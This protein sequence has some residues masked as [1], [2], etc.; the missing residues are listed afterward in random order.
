MYII[1]ITYKNAGF[2]NT[3]K[4]SSNWPIAKTLLF[5]QKPILHKIQAKSISYMKF[6][7]F[8]N[9]KVLQI[10][11]NSYFHLQ[12]FI[13]KIQKNSSL[14]HL[15]SLAYKALKVFSLITWEAVIS[16]DSKPIYTSTTI[17]VTKR[18]NF[19]LP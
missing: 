5:T 17:C 3:I 2:Y 19:N 14:S 16:L 9:S 1:S 10:L 8:W 12:Y 7:R 13:R 4:C 11:M 15:T 6:L 18:E